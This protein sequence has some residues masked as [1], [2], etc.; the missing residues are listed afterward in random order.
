VTAKT[1]NSLDSAL[2]LLS[3]E[4]FDIAISDLNLTGAC[5]QEGL[6]IVHFAKKINPGIRAFIWTAYDEQ[7]LRDTI[8]NTEVDGYLAKPVKFETLL[9]IIN[10]SHKV[11]KE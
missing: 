7:G 4:H 1:A 8:I 2:L 10:D 3:Q 11:P 5:G 6:E 9:S